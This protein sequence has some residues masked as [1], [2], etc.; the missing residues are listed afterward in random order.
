FNLYMDIQQRIN[1]AILDGLQKLGT[2]FALP[3]RT[4][5]VERA[6][7]DADLPGTSALRGGAQHGNSMP[8]RANA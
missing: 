4:I 1:L 5:R 6:G 8:P 3:T 7:D 2:A